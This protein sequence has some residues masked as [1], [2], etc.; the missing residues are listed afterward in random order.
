MQI[1][2]KTYVL[3]LILIHYIHQIDFFFF[4]FFDCLH[5]K[6]SARICLFVLEGVSNVSTF[7]TVKVKAETSG[8]KDR[9]NDFW[10]LDN[11]TNLT[12]KKNKDRLVRKQVL[13]FSC[14]NTIN[15]N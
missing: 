8:Q 10:F 15:R 6:R 7:K 14:Y 12:S 4:F 1:K 3:A 9:V 13:A 5:G 11:M 2:N